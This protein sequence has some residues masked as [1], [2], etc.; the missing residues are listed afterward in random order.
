MRANLATDD[1]ELPRPAY[2]EN[3]RRARP[4]GSSPPSLGRPRF[5]FDRLEAATSLA[6][7]AALPGNRLEAL[8]GDRAG[9]P[10]TVRFNSSL[11]PFDRPWLRL[12]SDRRDIPQLSRVEEGRGGLR[13]GQLLR[14][15]PPLIKPPITSILTHF[16]STSEV[17]GLCSAGVTRPQ[18]SYAPVRSRPA[19]R[20]KAMVEMRPPT[21]RVSPDY[22]CC[23][24]NVPCPL[25][26]RTEQG[27]A[28]M[29]CLFVRPSPSVRW[30]GVRIG[31][32]EACSGCTRVTAHRIA[33]PPE[34]AFVTRLRPDQSP[35]R[36]ARQLPDSS[37]FIR[38]EPPS[39]SNTR[40]RGAHALSPLSLSSQPVA[41]PVRRS[42]LK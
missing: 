25:P 29:A 2:R 22:P 20:L 40:L 15:P 7:L 39:T 28:S 18:R 31:S 13:H 6:D 21:G 10:V 12:T 35:S 41:R 16:A 24:S 26:R 27:H 23:P 37:T 11:D 9:V 42:I 36:T 1:R 4:S 34:A 32:F 5:G 17:R 38:V 30:V 33:Q 3:S 14:F 8:K 19:H